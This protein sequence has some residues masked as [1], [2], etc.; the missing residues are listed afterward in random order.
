M[1]K[2]VLLYNE[3]PMRRIMNA[4]V[5][6]DVSQAPPQIT[7]DNTMPSLEFID[8]INTA[9]RSCVEFI[10]KQDFQLVARKEA[11]AIA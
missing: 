10:W 6:S 7:F 5:Q 1:D 9:S 4:W 8:Q 2:V 3:H 11:D